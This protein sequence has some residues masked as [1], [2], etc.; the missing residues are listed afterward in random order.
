MKWHHVA[1]NWPAFFEA[2]ADRWSDVDE[3]ELYEID[4]DQRAFVAYIAR[5][6]DQTP[7]EATEEI[8][9]W[10]SG[11]VPTDIVMDSRHDNHS[12]ANAA[13]YVPDG[14]DESDDDSRFGDD[15]KDD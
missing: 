2:I 14:E 15:G 5:L 12:L 3:D 6:T 4:G 8:R 13:K 1:D 11:E 7:M 9:E 10:L